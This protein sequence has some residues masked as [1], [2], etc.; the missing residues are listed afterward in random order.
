MNRQEAYQTALRLHREQGL[1]GRRIHKIISHIP[2][3][4]IDRWI[5]TNSTPDYS[6]NRPNLA[7]SPSL[8]YILGVLY[9]DGYAFVHSHNYHIGLRVKD[10]EFAL[11]FCT[12]MNEINLYPSVRFQEGKYYRTD[13]SSKRFF[14]WFKKLTFGEVEQLI[15]SHEIEFIRGFYDSEGCLSPRSKC[16][17]FRIYL[18]NTNLELLYL[19]QKLLSKFGFKNNIREDGGTFKKCY[20]LHLLG[21]N[22]EIIRFLQLVQ[23]S[24]PRKSIRRIENEDSN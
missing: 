18:A 19:I 14:E 7:V 12:A 6:K 8:A 17:T 20:G 2:R 1:S 23:F 5:Y 9:G 22:D 15:T 24:I 13:V 3:G 21:G 10:K 16:K 4:T 11:A